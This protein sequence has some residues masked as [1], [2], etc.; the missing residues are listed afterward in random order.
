MRLYPTSAR[1][2]APIKVG[3][4]GLMKLICNHRGRFSRSVFGILRILVRGSWPGGIFQVLS[5]GLAM[6][7][8]PKIVCPFR[9]SR[10]GGRQAYL[11]GVEVF[12][13]QSRNSSL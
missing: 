11:A 9:E 12:F 5:G 3:I 4:I 2:E 8:G 7:S 13:F 1:A 6:G 10:G